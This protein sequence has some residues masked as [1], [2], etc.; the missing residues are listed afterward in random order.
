MSDVARKLLVKPGS[1]VRLVKAPP[2][3]HDLLGPLPAGARRVTSGAAD[4][5]VVFVTDLDDPDITYLEAL[6]RGRGR[7]EKHIS[8]AKDLGLSRQSLLYEIKKL[9]ITVD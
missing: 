8:D 4:V 9:G 1:T 2:G 3:A 7:A 6:H 5:V